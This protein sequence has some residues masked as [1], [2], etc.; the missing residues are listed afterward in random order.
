MLD[1]ADLAI[2]ASVQDEQEEIQKRGLGNREKGASATM[3]WSL[4]L[5]RPSFRLAS[6][7]WMTAHT[8]TDAI[9][10]QNNFPPRYQD[11]QSRHTGT[12][13]SYDRSKRRHGLISTA[14]TVVSSGRR[15][16][17]VPIARC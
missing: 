3:K 4:G 10:P 2:V 14:Y 16:G 1:D 6:P 11:L 5:A 13:P 12:H 7:W 8:D 17:R 15:C 9:I